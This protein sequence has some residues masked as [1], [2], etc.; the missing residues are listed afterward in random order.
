MAGTRVLTSAVHG[1][2]VCASEDMLT[3]CHQFRHR[4]ALNAHSCR[5]GAVR[6]LA[7]FGWSVGFG[8]R[9]ATERASEG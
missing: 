6:E 3:A 8:S 4:M 7:L 2:L 5:C 9:I 1:S